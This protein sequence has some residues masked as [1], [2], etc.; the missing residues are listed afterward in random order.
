MLWLDFIEKE[1]EKS[2]ALIEWIAFGSC[3]K[4]DH[5]R[6]IACIYNTLQFSLHLNANKER[7]TILITGF[8]GFI[9]SNKALKYENP[10]KYRYED[11]TTK[12]W[13]LNRIWWIPTQSTRANLIKLTNWILKIRNFNI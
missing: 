10:I 7:Q 13:N 1:T 5:F 6:I 8:C 3:E 2:E 9:D 11:A 4:I 12:W